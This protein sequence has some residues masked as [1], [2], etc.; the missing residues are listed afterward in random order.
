MYDILKQVKNFNPDFYQELVKDLLY[1]IPC[2]TSSYHYMRYLYVQTHGKF[3]EE[4]C[5]LY[6]LFRPKQVP[7]P[8]S[9]I[10][11][12]SNSVNPQ[13]NFSEAQAGLANDG[14]YQF[15]IGL[16]TELTQ[17]LQDI[18]FST[19]V[20]DHKTDRYI[21]PSTLINQAESYQATYQVDID[22]LLPRRAIQEIIL[23]P[24]L[25]F[26]A[27]EFLGCNPTLCTIAIWFSFPLAH[28]DSQQRD[29]QLSHA[30]QK[31][32]FDMDRIKFINVFI[33]LTDVDT[34]SGPFVY[35][36]GSHNQKPP[37]FRDGRYEDWEIADFYGSQNIIEVTGRAGSIFVANNFGFHK[38][39]PLLSGFRLVLQLV[40]SVS[41]FGTET[42]CSPVSTSVHGQDFINQLMQR[43]L[44]FLGRFSVNIET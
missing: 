13:I 29:I 8:C 25:L 22:K 31:F 36:K 5:N 7:L 23:D 37:Q 33:Y 6:S 2:S 44:S 16:S 21:L 28:S 26:L 12:K 43:K 41:L 32:H 30:A 3:N 11:V 24:S 10:L 19:P 18:I 38:G 14:I 42:Q 4:A 27:Q 34:N 1:G 15:P 40:Y 35:V 20:L 39:K 17:L 9:G